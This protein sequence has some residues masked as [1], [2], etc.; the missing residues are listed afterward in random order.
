M[1]IREGSSY[2]L[3]IVQ[4]AFQ[5]FLKIADLKQEKNCIKVDRKIEISLTETDDTVE[6]FK[7]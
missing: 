4:D 3:V 2:L 1:V 6:E 5:N 7:V